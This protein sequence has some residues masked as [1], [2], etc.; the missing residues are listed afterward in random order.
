[1]GKK[2]EI[3][4]PFPF[5]LYPFLFPPAQCPICCKINLGVKAHLKSVVGL[6]LACKPTHLHEGNACT[7]R[8]I[9]QRLTAIASVGALALFNALEIED[10]K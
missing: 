7:L 9:G 1:M 4:F 10:K 2:E 3:F 8:G 5:P 6:F